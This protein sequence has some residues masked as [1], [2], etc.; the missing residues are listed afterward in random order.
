MAR[1]NT[2]PRRIEVHHP[3]LKD[4]YVKARILEP[5]EAM[6]MFSGFAD[7]Q[8]V[9]A[10]VDQ[11]TGDPLYN[12]KGEPITSTITNIPASEI[13]RILASTLEGWDGLD[14]ENDKPIP[15]TEENLRILFAPELTIAKDVL[16]EDTGKKLRTYQQTFA[17]YIQEEINKKAMG[18]VQKDA[19]SGPKA[20]TSSKQ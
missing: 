20:K 11:R 6:D 10:V 18:E 19:Q 5:I 7:F 12:K 15:F 14:D 4:V 1:I 17:D 16:D 8:R 9:V 2:K 3:T 13:I